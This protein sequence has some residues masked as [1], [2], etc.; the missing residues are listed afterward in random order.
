[1]KTE[2]N[3]P[4]CAQSVAILLGCSGAQRWHIYCLLLDG[5]CRVL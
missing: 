3:L 1:M 4:D 5:N 2:L